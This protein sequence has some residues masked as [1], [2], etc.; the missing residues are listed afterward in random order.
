MLFNTLSVLKK[1]DNSTHQPFQFSYLTILGL[2]TALLLITGCDLTDSDQ[3][4]TIFETDF[5][6]ENTDWD[7][8]YTGYTVSDE[9][10]MEFDNGIKPL[11]EPLNSSENGYYI[12]A[13]NRSDNV[14]MLLRN[15]IDGLDPNTT[16]SVRFTVRFA[17]EEPSG[18]A[19][20]G[21]A[22][23]EAV[24]VIADASE[25]RP[26]PII[27]NEGDD[28]YYLL[29]I[30]YMGDS[31]E[32]Y[33]N[34]IMGNIANSRECEDGEEFEI[35]E[36]TSGLS[37]STVTTNENG[38]AWLMFGTRSGFEGQTELYYTYFK[39]EFRK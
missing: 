16:Y 22:P 39:A 6:S 15:R 21:G 7:P 11:P 32:W 28:G 36:V 26:E 37:H 3:D 10:N 8:F 25:V 9:E 35:K 30:Q 14:K 29:N 20:V 17:T 34:A 33:Q 13:L 19:G 31:Q 18:C 5:R 4:A 27:E 38:E 24:K 2:I 23:G 12:T 1:N